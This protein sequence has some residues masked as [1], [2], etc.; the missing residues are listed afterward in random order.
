MQRLDK[1]VKESGDSNPWCTVKNKKPKKPKK[2]NIKPNNNSG[3]ISRSEYIN[4]PKSNNNR[5]RTNGNS[6]GSIN[7]SPTISNKF[8]NRHN[9][10]FSRFNKISEDKDPK[11]VYKEPLYTG[12]NY[13]SVTKEK[14]QENNNGDSIPITEYIE[15]RNNV[16]S[17][18]IFRNIQ[19]VRNQ[20]P[21]IN[22]NVSFGVWEHTYFKH[23]LDL[24]DIFS[25]GVN[26]LDIDT[27]SF[28]FLS[29]F[30]NFIR[31][32]SSGEISPY[33]EDIDSKTDE[34]YM[35][36]AIKRNKF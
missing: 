5:N 1:Q 13:A 35:E 12:P 3:N 11:H 14:E 6:R 7:E 21:K 36:Y 33:I 24:S 32:C 8:S 20:V 27:K 30:S 4:K 31:K 22:N 16:P 28:E 15:Y 18:P 25:E 17:I 34:L 2:T 23:I 19:T 29:I 10:R 26:K 9:D